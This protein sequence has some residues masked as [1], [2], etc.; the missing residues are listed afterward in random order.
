MI[1]K[2]NT[3]TTSLL[4]TCNTSYIMAPVPIYRC[5]FNTIYILGTELTWN[6]FSKHLL[7]L[8]IQYTGENSLELDIVDELCVYI[9]SLRDT[10]ADITDCMNNSS[11]ARKS[12]RL[13]NV[14]KEGHNYYE[15]LCS[16][17]EDCGSRHSGNV[18]SD[19]ISVDNWFVKELLGVKG[20]LYDI[21][22]LIH[23]IKSWYIDAV[24]MV[25]RYWV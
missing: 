8:T 23:N 10:L 21:M 16:I 4:R 6:K 13:W 18:Y 3:P 5:R 20:H 14:S 19:N 17:V 22:Q 7:T 12:S 15:L 11:K 1:F 24:A 2:T 9:S 25:D